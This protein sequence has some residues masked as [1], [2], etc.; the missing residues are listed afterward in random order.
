MEIRI[1][2]D[3]CVGCGICKEICSV[4]AIQMAYAGMPGTEYFNSIMVRDRCIGCGDC[5]EWCPVGA[6]WDADSGSPWGGLP[7]GSSNDWQTGFGGGGGGFPEYSDD[8]SSEAYINSV[9]YDIGYQVLSRME[10]KM[11]QDTVCFY[12]VDR[13]TQGLLTGTSLALSAKTS[14]F[15][16]IDALKAGCELTAKIGRGVNIAGV[17][18]SLLEFGIGIW[19][20]EA[21]TVD[22]VNLGAAL[23]GGGAVVATFI[24]PPLV[25]PLG[26]VCVCLTIYSGA[27]TF[28]E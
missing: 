26:V 28:C 13:A 18:L 16:I 5:I 9:D 2:V 24:C 6:I 20:G 3:S 25:L 4:D 1:D 27:L 14:G 23:T 8:N 12:E 21:E 7:G 19:D 17:A 10:E 22:W 15:I 11:M